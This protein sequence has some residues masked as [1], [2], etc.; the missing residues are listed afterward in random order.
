[1]FVFAM[2][3]AEI[4]STTPFTSSIILC[5]IINAGTVNKFYYLDALA[6]P[7]SHTVFLCLD[8]LI[9]SDL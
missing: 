1:M 5:I 4:R 3:G 9:F 7:C 8:F 6:I 2:R